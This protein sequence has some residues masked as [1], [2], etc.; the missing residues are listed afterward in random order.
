[1]GR[2]KLI[3][4]FKVAIGRRIAHARRLLRAATCSLVGP[5]VGGGLVSNSSY[6]MGAS[7]G[8]TL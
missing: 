2:E 3:R 6:S 5:P 4:R 1:M 7:A 8:E